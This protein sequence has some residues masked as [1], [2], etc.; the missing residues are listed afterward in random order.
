MCKAVVNQQVALVVVAEMSTQHTLATGKYV[1]GFI[2]AKYFAFFHFLKLELNLDAVSMAQRHRHVLAG[3][4]CQTRCCDDD[5]FVYFTPG[6]EAKI[7]KFKI[8]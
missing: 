8:Q 7:I 1:T 5:T 6:W 3:F 2:F 4:V